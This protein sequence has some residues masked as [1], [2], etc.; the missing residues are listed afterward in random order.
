GT[1][2]ITAPEGALRVGRVERLPG[3]YEI[4]SLTYGQTD[5]LSNP[6]LAPDTVSELRVTLEVNE[7]APFVK[8]SG[9]FAGLNAGE[10][11]RVTLTGMSAAATFETALADGAFEFPRV[12]PGVYLVSLIRNGNSVVAEPPIIAVASKN[13]RGITFEAPAPP[14]PAAAAN[15]SRMTGNEAA[16]VANLRTINTAEVTF[17]STTG[18]EFGDVSELVAAGLLD[19]RFETS[20]SGYLFAISVTDGD[21]VAAAAPVNAQAGIRGFFT[22][23]E[24]VVRFAV[25]EGLAPPGKAGE[26]VE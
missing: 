1:F 12:A 11:A 18:G 25:P 9:R 15:A 23:P 24:G 4:K 7:A 17:L 3:G 5:L 13:R 20:V 8:V 2:Q 16:T 19:T 21:Y 10:S 26:P 6:L 22:T 14:Q